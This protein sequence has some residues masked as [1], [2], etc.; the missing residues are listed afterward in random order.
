MFKIKDAWQ[1]VEAPPADEGTWVDARDGQVYTWK[2]LG[3]QTWMT[4]NFN[5]GGKSGDWVNTPNA[6]SAGHAYRFQNQQDYGNYEAQGWTFGAYYTLASLEWAVPDGWHVP[7]RDEINTLK[8]WAMETYG[9]GA[10]GNVTAQMLG[11]AALMNSCS[12]LWS[13]YGL[14]VPANKH[15]LTGFNLCI[16]ST[17]WSGSSWGYIT[18]PGAYNF[19]NAS[20]L[21]L[22]DANGSSQYY[23]NISEDSQYSYSGPN[24]SISSFT[25]GTRALPIRLIK[26]A[27]TSTAQPIITNIVTTVDATGSDNKIPTEKATRTAIEDA[28]S[29]KMSNPMTASG[30]LII[31][32]TLGAPTVLNI[33][34]VGKVLT[35]GSNGIGWEDI[36]IQNGDHKVVTSSTDTIPDYLIDKISAGNGIQISEYIYGTNHSIVI[37]NTA[38]DGDHQAQVSIVD[39]SAGYLEDKI[40]AG[41]GIT[42]NVLSDSSGFQTL[43]ISSSGGGGGMINPMTAVGD[44]IVGGS[45]GAPTRLGVGSPGQ[46]LKVGISGITWDDE[47]VVSISDTNSIDLTID[48]NG[49]LTADL[50]ID[51]STPGNVQLS[52][53]SN[54][55]TGSF[56]ETV[57]SLFGM[58]PIEISNDVN[59]EYTVS[60]AVSDKAGNK[61]EI[62]NGQ[63]QD[64]PGIYV[65]TPELDGIIASAGD[66]I[67]GDSNGDPSALAKGSKY[68]TLSVDVNGAVGWHGPEVVLGLQEEYVSGQ[69]F[70]TEFVDTNNRA[71]SGYE[72]KLKK[73]NAGN[74]GQHLELVESTY[75]GGMMTQNVPAWVD[76]PDTCQEN[77]SI[78]MSSKKENLT[79]NPNRIYTTKVVSHKTVKRTK[80]GFYHCTG[81]QGRVQM[82]VY[83]ELGVLIGETGFQTFASAPD[84][85]MVWFDAV[86]PFT[87]NAG[88]EYWFAFWAGPAAGEYNVSLTVLEYDHTQAFDQNIIGSCSH[89]A[90]SSGLPGTMPSMQYDTV[91]VHMAVK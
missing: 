19:T 4:Q 65:P 76:E 17:G 2:K 54:G 24:I 8:T 52:V 51:S 47:A 6:Q 46:V 50:K 80:F 69:L 62:V 29:G 55:L 91:A 64:S 27:E 13:S 33:G 53:S 87:M 1:I 81:Q 36:P 31:G 32:G 67:I 63:G 71:G 61:V 23:L 35:V 30:D 49:D 7:T 10:S 22:A 26:D 82:G 28:V 16:N 56:D 45:S 68:E 83:N 85:Q 88:E 34:S 58:N 74:A 89:I 72:L 38:M 86:A 41:A 37:E 77:F 59:D 40:V 25:P 57:K 12:N 60:L 84:E 90:Q 9:S 21:W 42:I 66:L 44:I 14:K 15:N 11:N 18:T 70:Y 75:M 78:F 5:Y 43:E 79:S 3:N 48:Q 39:D 20:Y 73:L